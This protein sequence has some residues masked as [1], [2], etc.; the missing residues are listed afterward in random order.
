MRERIVPEITWQQFPSPITFGKLILASIHLN[1]TSLV[2]GNFIYNVKPTDR[3]P[4]GSLPITAKFI[5]TV[6]PHLV[7]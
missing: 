6:L 2:P 3:P 5:P 4:V 7:Y 1:A